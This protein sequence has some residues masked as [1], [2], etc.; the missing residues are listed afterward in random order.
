MP[1]ENE[2]V[3]IV[4][5]KGSGK[6]TRA[7]Q[8]LETRPRRVV[9]DAM[10]EHTDGV[11]VKTFADLAAYVRDKRHARYSVILRA[12]DPMHVLDAIALA[13]ATAPDGS[14]GDPNEAP[15][16][17][18]WYLL[19]EIDRWATPTS[20]PPPIFNLANYG[21]HFGVSMI[22][23]ARRAQRVP[24]DFRFNADRILI[25]R[26]EEPNDLDYLS[27]RVPGELLERAR[28]IPQGEFIEWEG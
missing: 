9:I 5:K 10:W 20:V 26:V 14:T 13:T 1:R 12:L 27:D 4:G 24:L 28:D 7:R 19:D 11:I 25:G 16:P 21:R 2:I 23:T 17:G 6:S 22:V 8:L 3:V 15:L 18:A